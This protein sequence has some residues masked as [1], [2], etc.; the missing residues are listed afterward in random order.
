MATLALF[1]SMDMLAYRFLSLHAAAW[2]ERACGIAFCLTLPAFREIQSALARKLFHLIAKYSYG[3]YLSH[4]AI[5]W[6]AFKVL[7]G[8]HAGV[9]ILA[10]TVLMITV[11]L[12]FYH[13]VEEPFIRLG[14]RLA[15]TRRQETL[16]ASV[17]A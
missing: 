6:F 7:G 8:Q 9:K 12:L 10:F 3:I 2:V 1:V 15:K 4:F 14:V 16:A 17:A 5:M 13:L 11:P